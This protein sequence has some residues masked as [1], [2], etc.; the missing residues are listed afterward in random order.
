MQNGQCDYTTEHWFWSMG[1]VCF[2]QITF[3]YI[4]YMIILLLSNVVNPRTANLFF[5]PSSCKLGSWGTPRVSWSENRCWSGNEVYKYTNLFVFSC[6]RGWHEVKVRWKKLGW[7]KIN[8]FSKDAWKT[9]KTQ[10]FEQKFITF[11]LSNRFWNFKRG[12]KGDKWG[13]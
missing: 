10:F 12:F 2:V 6:W 11:F 9:V 3:A 8:F 4:E 7:G 1:S 5:S 13:F